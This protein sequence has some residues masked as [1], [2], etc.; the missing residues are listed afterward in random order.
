MA[1]SPTARSLKAL[2]ADGWLCAIVEKWNRFA[3]VRQD[4]YGFIDLLCVRGGETLAVQ[5]TTAGHVA[6]RLA[7]IRGSKHLAA[8]LEAG[9]RVEVHGWAKPTKTIRTWRQRVVIVDVH[10]QA[11]VEAA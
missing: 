4:L 3:G 2:R 7:K 5:A 10:G 11:E 9:W 1:G 6:H 8:V